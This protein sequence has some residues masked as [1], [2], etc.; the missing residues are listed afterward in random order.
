MDFHQNKVMWQKPMQ[1]DRNHSHHVELEK[2]KKDGSYLFLYATVYRMV[3]P[4][5]KM[6]YTLTCPG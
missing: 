1:R 3:E 6:S 2:R 4:L 5:N